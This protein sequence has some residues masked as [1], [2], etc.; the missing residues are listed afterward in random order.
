M[1]ILSSFKAAIAGLM[2]WTD[3]SLGAQGEREAVRL[4]KA[5]GYDI[6][7]LNLRFGGNADGNG[8]WGEIDVLAQDPDGRTIVLVEVKTR[9]RAAGSAGA[10]A[11]VAPEASV[12]QAKARKLVRLMDAVVRA[13]G[14]QQRPKRIDVVAVEFIER[15]TGPDEVR[16]RH[17]PGAVRRG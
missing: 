13:N 8:A 3:R 4:L 16:S 6:L 11:R 12:T 17:F 14:W 9:R 10:S 7:G 15:P 5:G 2:S 1:G